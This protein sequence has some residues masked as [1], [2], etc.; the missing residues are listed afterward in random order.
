MV[1]KHLLSAYIETIL[2]DEVYEIM[3][4]DK[5]L[6]DYLAED[7]CKRFS[8]LTKTEKR[9][10]DNFVEKAEVMVKSINEKG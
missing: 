9:K 8:I 5:N 3:K 6:A 2:P 1:N 10:L 4:D 7:L